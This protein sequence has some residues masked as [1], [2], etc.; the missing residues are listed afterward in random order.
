[1]PLIQEEF[2]GTTIIGFRSVKNLSAVFDLNVTFSAHVDDILRRCS[3]L[4]SRLSHSRHALPQD[5][6]FTVMQA[7]LVSTVR[8]YISVY[9]QCMQQHTNGTTAEIAELWC[10]SYLR[11]S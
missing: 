9:V 10:T 1:M 6:L 4:L 11:P 8:Y 7:L 5:T 3:G 2:M